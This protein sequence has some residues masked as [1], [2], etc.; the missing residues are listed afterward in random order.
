MEDNIDDDKEEQDDDDDDIPVLGVETQVIISESRPKVEDIPKRGRYDDAPIS[1][2]SVIDDEFEDDETE[3]DE[4]L[5]DDDFVDEFPDFAIESS[6][7]RPDDRAVIYDGIIGNEVDDYD[8]DYYA[9]DDYDEYY[10]GDEIDDYYEE[11]EYLAEPVPRMD[12][13]GRY[14]NDFAVDTSQ[15]EDFDEDELDE[16]WDED[17]FD[18][19]EAVGDWDDSYEDDDD[20]DYDS[21]ADDEFLDDD[22]VPFDSPFVVS[23]PAKPPPDFGKTVAQAAMAKTGQPI[24]DAPIPDKSQLFVVSEPGGR[25]PADFGKAV[26]EASN[27]KTGG[28]IDFKTAF[29]PSNVQKQISQNP[30]MNVISTRQSP[31]NANDVQ[32]LTRSKES[33]MD[34]GMTTGSMMSPRIRKKGS[35]AEQQ[36]P[37]EQTP[38]APIKTRS[39]GA[40]SQPTFGSAVAQAASGLSDAIG[41]PTNQDDQEVDFV[42]D[43]ALKFYRRTWKQKPPEA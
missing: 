8:D 41:V 7:R 2:T 37:K 26:A 5:Y 36:T 10:E 19:E 9:E 6:P 17:E 28:P 35:E 11:E 29:M 39:G 34:Y 4:E 30:A 12:I 16:Y 15:D 23:E 20:Y 33:S 32:S 24:N 31:L 13:A 1:T 40:Y 21:Y 14:G 3:D 38:A 25:P 27:A 42:D 22:D 18:E 43:A